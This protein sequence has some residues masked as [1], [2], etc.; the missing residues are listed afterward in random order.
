MDLSRQIFKEPNLE[1][2]GSNSAALW[3]LSSGFSV[4]SDEMDYVSKN[5]LWQHLFAAFAEDTDGKTEGTLWCPQLTAAPFL[6]GSAA[7]EREHIGRRVLAFVH[8][9]GYF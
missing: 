7:A 8:D 3:A 4:G 6:G 1:R 2:G 5:S 9:I